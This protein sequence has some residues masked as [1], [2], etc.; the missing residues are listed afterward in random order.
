V[1]IREVARR[2]LADETGKVTCATDAARLNREQIPTPPDRRAQ[3]CARPVK[4]H[5][6]TAKT[7][8]HVLTSE[9]ALGFLR[10]RGLERLRVRRAAARYPCLRRL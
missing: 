4:G 6:W 2:I 5:M 10:A 1:V 8:K 7:V 9:A 3:L